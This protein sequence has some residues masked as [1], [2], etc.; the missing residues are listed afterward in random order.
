MARTQELVSADLNWDEIAARAADHGVRPA[1]IA[2]LS[3]VDWQGVPPSIRQTLEGFQHRH[4]LSVLG[5]AEEIARVARDLATQAVPFAVFKGAAL[6]LGLY[7]QM[8]AREFND[9]DVIVPVGEIAR[10]E[11]VLV[12]RGYRP[13]IA[14]PAFR[15]F[16][17][18]H[19]GQCAF[20]GP[21]GA[22]G[23][24]LHWSFAGAFLP[25]PLDRRS[26]WSRL[27]GVT[28]AGVDV[29]VLQPEDVV[30]V[31]AG[32][33]TKEGWRSLMWLRDFAFAV[34]RWTELDWR[35]IHCRA[36]MCGSGDA[37][38]LACA[39]VERVL[40]VPP[41]TALVPMISSN[42]RVAGLAAACAGRLLAGA[43][44]KRHLDDL[45]LCDRRGDRLRAAVGLALAPTP[46][47]HAALPLPRPLWPAYYA[48][49]PLRL[50]AKV[51]RGTLPL[52]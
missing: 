48:L 29:P 13:A 30:L 2:L 15:R 8:A 42:G 39:V 28:I 12:R 6:S 45:A 50:A 22:A 36:R 24:D 33:G 20:A 38:L 10:A 19:Q 47:D 43:V 11:Q 46:A 5:L 25:F 31:L 26:L 51:V 21:D 49:R 23:V 4:L 44:D 35:D 7:Q 32:H 27:A 34:D 16:F 9:I 40:G 14:D 41:P 17:Q 3:A 37:V 1:L 52:P 18:G